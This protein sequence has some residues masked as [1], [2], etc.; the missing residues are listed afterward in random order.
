MATILQ[1]ILVLL[2]VYANIVLLAYHS[3][4]WE[5][6]FDMGL[7]HAPVRFFLILPLSVLFPIS[8]L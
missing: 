5:R 7:I 8:L 1:G 3:P 4:T 2:L 6:P